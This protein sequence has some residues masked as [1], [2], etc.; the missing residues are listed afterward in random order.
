MGAEQMRLYFKHEDFQRLPHMLKRR[1]WS[2]TNY[3]TEI[4]S[5]ELMEAIKC[6]LEQATV[7]KPPTDIS[8]T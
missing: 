7:S 1:W 3:G 6:A 8:K 4:P 5:V 2:E